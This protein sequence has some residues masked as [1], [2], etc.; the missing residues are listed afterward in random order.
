[1]NNL[2]WCIQTFKEE[3]FSSDTDNSIKTGVTTIYEGAVMKKHTESANC[4]YH[5]LF[6]KV[7]I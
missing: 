2:V 6:F 4:K 7:V 3:G 5:N 1:M